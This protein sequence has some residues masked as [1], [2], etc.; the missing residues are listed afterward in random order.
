MR[1]PSTPSRSEPRRGRG[2]PFIDLLFR[3][4][5]YFGLIIIFVLA[6]IFSPERNGVNLFLSSR[7]LLNVLMFASET[8]ILA[9]G[10]T[11]V[12]L[13]GGIDLSVGSVMALIGVISADLLMNTYELS[14]LGVPLT[15]G[16]WP[17][18]LIVALCVII[19]AFIGFLGSTLPGTGIPVPALIMIFCA[20]LFGLILRYTTFGRRIYAVGAIRQRR[21]SRGF[22]SD[23]YASSPS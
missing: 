2:Q 3:F 17:A 1:T 22:A 9:V 18:G 6:I 12:I 14:L 11:L 19:G 4:Q 7:N 8:A 16:Q 15:I 13:V 21:G 5:S 10:M 20:V 23:D